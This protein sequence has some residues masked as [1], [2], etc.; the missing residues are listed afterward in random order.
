[1]FEED[2]Y[3]NMSVK[4]MLEDISK[5]ELDFDF[6]STMEILPPT[7]VPVGNY[8]EEVFGYSPYCYSGCYKAT[9]HHCI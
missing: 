9:T 5:K 1:M 4:E 2:I 7:K 6:R 3:E 8:V